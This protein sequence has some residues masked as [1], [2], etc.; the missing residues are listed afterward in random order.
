[1]IGPIA[2][3][4]KKAVP[5]RSNIVRFPMQAY[6]NLPAFLACF[7]V[8][9]LPFARNDA[10]RAIS[11]TK[12]LEYLAG[13]RPV[14]STP[15]ADVTE[16]YGDVVSVATSSREFVR[17]VESVLSRSPREEDEWLVMVDALIA[18]NEWDAIA[19]RMREIMAHATVQ[20]KTAPKLLT[21]G[22]RG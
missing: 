1:L 6:Q 21:D 11:P 9:I 16:L 2:K 17:E 19:E 18:R 10:T 13:G 22:L 20:R 3:I 15:I 8:A 5:T 4:D 12:T 14:V 7:D